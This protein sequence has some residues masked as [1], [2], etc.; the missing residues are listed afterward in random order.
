MGDGGGEPTGDSPPAATPTG[1]RARREFCEHFARQ[2]DTLPVPK[3]CPRFAESLT[4]AGQ[5]PFSCRD[6]RMHECALGFGLALHP[7]TC[8]AE[9]RISYMSPVDAPQLLRLSDTLPESC[10][11]QRQAYSC[12]ERAAVR[13]RTRTTT[14]LGAGEH[15]S[16]A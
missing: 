2:L 16:G 6:A 5:A 10:V 4:K 8:C 13:N 11:A 12:A 7:P 14:D 15:C 9:M 1:N 3:P